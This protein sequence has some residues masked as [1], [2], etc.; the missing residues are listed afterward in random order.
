M[1]ISNR[2][3]WP[4]IHRIGVLCVPVCS[5]IAIIRSVR[6]VS[7]MCRIY[8]AQHTLRAPHTQQTPQ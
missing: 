7:E 3:S 2:E 8:A 5:L 6:S 1:T 4:H